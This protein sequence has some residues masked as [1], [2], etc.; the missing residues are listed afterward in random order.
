M[1]NQSQSQN[2]KR[3]KLLKRCGLPDLPETG[4]CF[5][6]RTHHT[7]CMLGPKTRQYANSS[8]NPIGALSVKVQA[9]R[10]G[11]GN[12]NKNTKNTKKISKTKKR[13]GNLT[14]WC[15]CT[16]SKVCTYY[17]TKFGKDNGTH[18]K[19][20]GTLSNKKNENTAIKKLNLY[21]HMTSGVFS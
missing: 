17:S 4:H 18:I 12:S 15:T 7:C 21:R 8:G 3:K 5:A 1:S 19:F 6:D 13:N 20:I 10:N 9:M 11:N 16:G 2:L 14:P